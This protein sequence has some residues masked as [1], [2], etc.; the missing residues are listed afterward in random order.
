MVTIP[1]REMID[2][3]TRDWLVRAQNLSTALGI[4]A[5]QQWVKLHKDMG[6]WIAEAMDAAA[7]G[8]IAKNE[9]EGEGS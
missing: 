4:D 3:Q 1:S 5:A 9:A 6:D 2:G 8:V 7:E